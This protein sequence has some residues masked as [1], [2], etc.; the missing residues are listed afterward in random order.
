MGAIS[1]GHVMQKI[2]FLHYLNW[3]KKIF[4]IKVKGKNESLGEATVT[5]PVSKANRR[6]GFVVKSFNGFG[7]R[8]LDSHLLALTFKLV[9]IRIGCFKD[10][11]S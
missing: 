8:R 9:S 11:G 6:V 4:A 7:L 10:V 1:N 5:P 2:F 3:C